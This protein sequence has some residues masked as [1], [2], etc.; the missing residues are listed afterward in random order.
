MTKH[1]MAKSKVALAALVLVS[2]ALQAIPASA[3]TYPITPAQKAT[4]NQVAEKGVPLSE[5]AADAPDS[6]TIKRGDTLWAISGIFL[7]DRG[8]GLSCGA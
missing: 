3:E 7:K 8:A 5:L 1:T 2:G 6:Y 4:A